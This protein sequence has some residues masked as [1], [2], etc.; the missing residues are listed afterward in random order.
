M[1]IDIRT[2]GT[3]QRRLPCGGVRRLRPQ[4]SEREPR[5]IHRIRLRLE[6][7]QICQLHQRTRLAYESLPERI[8][9]RNMESTDRLTGIRIVEININVQIKTMSTEVDTNSNPETESRSCPNCEKKALR[10]RGA[11]TRANVLRRTKG[12]IHDQWI[13]DECEWSGDDS[14]VSDYVPASRKL[15]DYKNGMEW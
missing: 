3:T 2:H 1:G 5:R 13:C 15:Y 9:N 12:C 4:T 8:C 11:N 6:R 7:I 14:H 10:R